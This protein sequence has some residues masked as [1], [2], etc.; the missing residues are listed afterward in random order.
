M[1]GK[2]AGR[3][4]W[5][6]AAN[7]VRCGIQHFSLKPFYLVE[8]IGVDGVSG[9][10]VHKAGFSGI[11]DMVPRWCYVSSSNEWWTFAPHWSRR[12]GS[13][14]VKE[15]SYSFPLV[16]SVQPTHFARFLSATRRAQF[17]FSLG[18]STCA[19]RMR[20]FWSG[21]PPP[22]KVEWVRDWPVY[23]EVKAAVRL[24][25][26][27]YFYFVSL[28]ARWKYLSKMPRHSLCQPE[29]LLMKH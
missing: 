28:N 15:V 5:R 8:C 7:R 3:W 22:A 29:L 21:N 14:L 13:T 10:A 1:R 26:F 20:W 12:R 9:N 19:Q 27:V 6:C 24:F 18:P 4:V 25:L 17:I 16:S 23:D 11:N 2:D